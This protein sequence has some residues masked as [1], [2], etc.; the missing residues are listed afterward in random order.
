MGTKE[1]SKVGNWEAVGCAKCD[2]MFYVNNEEEA[3]N[4]I[5][6]HVCGR[7]LIKQEIGELQEGISYNN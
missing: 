5:K 2:A 4:W 1:L 7:K 3:D 6:N